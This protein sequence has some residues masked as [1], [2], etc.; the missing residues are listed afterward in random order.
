[1]KKKLLF[2]AL[3]GATF[4]FATAAHAELSA[5][6][7]GKVDSK[8]PYG[9]TKN[10]KL[11]LKNQEKLANLDTKYIE[12]STNQQ[13]LKE[14][15]DGVKSVVEGVNSQYAKLNIQIPQLKDQLKQMDENL[16]LEIDH[17]KDYINESRKIQ[18]S[19]YQ[20]IKL[21]LDELSK[22]VDNINSNYISRQ[23]LLEQLKGLDSEKPAEKTVENTKE[24]E[25][26]EQLVKAPEEVVEPELVKP[27]KDDSW[28]SKSLKE[29][30]KLALSEEKGKKYDDASEKFEFLI[31]K[32]YY[33]ATNNFYLGE[34][35]YK[36]KDYTSAIA[37]YKKSTALSTKTKFMPKLLY[38]TA[39]S[40]DKVGDTK[41]ANQFYRALKLSY[42]K[43][44]E[45]KASPD[46]K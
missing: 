36:L 42:P 12:V 29:I 16:S 30:F 11:L 46:R 17:L 5:F 10:E 39:I 41:S 25:E 28:K 26:D 38:H 19:N 43:S 9:L 23:S 18:E 45:A 1:M 3:L 44:A 20:Q 7:A 37:Y 24:Q 35:K 40:L 32:N 34:I 33:K 22:L 13:N 27:P 2:V 8:N 21:V 31:K 4:F 15:L 14:S 6:N